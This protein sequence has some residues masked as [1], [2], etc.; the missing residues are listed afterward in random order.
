MSKT[1]TITLRV[2]PELKQKLIKL[3]ETD[4]RS[5]NTTCEIGLENLIA[6]RQKSGGKK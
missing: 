5:L 1:A 3:A 2:K 4:K 6:E